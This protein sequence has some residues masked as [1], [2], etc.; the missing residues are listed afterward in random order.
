MARDNVSLGVIDAPAGMD[1]SI[2]HLVTT[3]ER[4]AK[5]RRHEMIEGAA[6]RSTA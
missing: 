2:E 6:V 4:R 1:F 3:G 5:P